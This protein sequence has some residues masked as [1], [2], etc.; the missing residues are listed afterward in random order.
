MDTDLW[1]FGEKKNKGM[2]IH[3]YQKDNILFIYIFE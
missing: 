3:I 2:N 1:Q